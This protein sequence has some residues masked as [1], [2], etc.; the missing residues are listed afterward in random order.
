MPDKPT[1]PPTPPTNDA[2]DS[3][4][5]DPVENVLG[6][7]GFRGEVAGCPTGLSRPRPPAA[8]KKDAQQPGAEKVPDNPPPPQTP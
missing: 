6:G 3:D 1:P 2:T 8:P 4:W 7:R 5:A